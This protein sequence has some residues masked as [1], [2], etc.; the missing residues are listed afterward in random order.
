MK[1]KVVR[2]ISVDEVIGALLDGEMI[3]LP[4]WQEGTFIQYD[5]LHEVL[6][7]EEDAIDPQDYTI[8]CFLAELAHSTCVKIVAYEDVPAEKVK[9]L[10]NKAQQEIDSL[11]EQVASL[12]VELTKLKKNLTNS[13]KKKSGRGK[14]A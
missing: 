3:A 1:L 10:T 14:N 2:T 11:K 12:T 13:T 9:A 8:G 6:S 5:A 4:G 7:N